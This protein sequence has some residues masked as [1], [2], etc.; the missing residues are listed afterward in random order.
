MQDQESESCG[1]DPGKGHPVLYQRPTYQH[2][3][4]R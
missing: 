4:T 1:H 3:A 2:I